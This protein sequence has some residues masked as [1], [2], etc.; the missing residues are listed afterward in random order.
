MF[1]FKGP[2]PEM[3][4]NQDL[5]QE[6]FDNFTTTDDHGMQITGIAMDVKG[7]KYFR[8]KNSWGLTGSPYKG[9]LYASESYVRYK[10]IAI[11][12][13]K[14]GIPEQIRQKLQIK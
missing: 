1:G 13:N 12:V 5:R 8:V 6:G 11:M 14:K 2:V 9:Y 7:N 10:T 3:R 4:I